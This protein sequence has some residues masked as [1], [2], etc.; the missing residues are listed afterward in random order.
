[1]WNTRNSKLSFIEASD[2]KPLVFKQIEREF[3]QAKPY[4]GE[5]EEKIA[6]EINKIISRFYGTNM[7]INDRAITKSM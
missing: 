1:L 4:Y 2:G 3:G 7:I 6:K 5:E